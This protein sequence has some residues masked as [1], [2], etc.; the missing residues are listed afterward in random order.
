MSEAPHPPALHPDTIG[1]YHVL[2]V[3]GEG[4]MG[5]VYAAEQLHPVR[6]RVAIKMMKVGLDSREVV[7]RFQAER[8]ALAVMDHPG[9]AKIL[10]AGVSES[11]R[12]YFVMELV[13][14]I[15]IDEYCDRFRLTVPE[16]LEL[17]IQLCQAVQH[18][19][20]KGVIHRDLKPTN[21]LVT[22]QDMRAVPKIIDFGIA[23]ATAQHLSDAPVVTTLGQAM[24]TLAYMS[25]EQAEGSELDVDTRA[26][27]YSLGIILFELLVGRVPLDPK[28]KGIP[29]FLSQ[30]VSRETPAPTLS[31]RLGDPAAAA[32]A[33]GIDPAA[34][35]RLIRGDLQWI[36][37]KAIDKDRGRRY[38]TAN[39]FA[40]D[41]GR[42]LADEPVLARP[43]STRYRLTKMVRRHRGVAVA[44]A[45]AVVALALGATAAGVGFVRARAATRQAQAARAQAETEAATA[46]QVSDFLI[47]LFEVNDPMV[48]RGGLMTVREILD[49]GARRVDAELPDQPVVQAR[50]MSA[51]GTVYQGLGLYDDALAL[52]QRALVLREASLTP[53]DL[54]VAESLQRL[55]NL[56]RDRG[57]L[58]ASEVNLGKALII[59]EAKL[60]PDADEVGHTLLSL[61]STILARGRPAEAE[62]LLTR[63]LAMEERVLGSEHEKVAAVVQEL[64]TVAY[65]LGEYPKA[66]QY[67]ARAI[68]IRERQLGPDHPEIASA[69]NNLGGVYYLEGRYD[70]A[71]RSYEQARA[72]WAKALEPDHPRFGVVLTNI[73]ETYVALGR[74]DDAEALLLEGLRIKERNLSPNEPSIAT[75]LTALADTYRDQG[76]MGAAEPRYLRAL[77]ILETVFGT[78]HPR[79]RPVLE[80][81]AEML[82]RDG[83][84]EA[85]TAVE[86]RISELR[87]EG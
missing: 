58:E 17:F 13:K 78:N 50:M 67:W 38:E 6:R 73:G 70:E 81:Y 16:R 86:R 14:G 23:K 62:P 65:Y 27:I 2:N 3:I 32:Q 9:I 77:Q 35:L 1:P 15:R 5:V 39:G 7:A 72:I 51:M 36:V 30:L 60:G 54:E 61:G 4:G 80:P 52:L 29:Q 12:P 68:S 85:A 28:E 48:A 44:G 84:Q 56:Q 24:G 42:F 21:V 69:L 10:D 63:A 45:L 74:L 55:G 8:E 19:H 22:E 34:L 66:S 71:L 53:D 43:P 31:N 25:P 20:Q 57:D 64:G 49:R 18:A 75:T 47:N 82:R 26:D 76:R 37:M 46:R 79:L 33:R 83:R 40:L 59:Q 11:G 87:S 41:L